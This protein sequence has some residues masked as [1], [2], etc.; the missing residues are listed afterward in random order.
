MLKC[1]MIATGGCK[2]KITVSHWTL[3]AFGL[4]FFGAIGILCTRFYDAPLL[5][6]PF[7]IIIAAGVLIDLWCISCIGDFGRVN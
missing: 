7:F 5:E 6:I 1:G 2:M 4:I 3:V